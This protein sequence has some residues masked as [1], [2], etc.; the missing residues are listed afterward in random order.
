[1]TQGR[2]IGCPQFSGANGHHLSTQSLTSSVKISRTLVSMKP[3]HLMLHREEGVILDVSLSHSLLFPVTLLPKLA[4][5]L[6][7]VP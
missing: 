4:P 2:A 3:H 5:S 7:S 6:Y 1:M